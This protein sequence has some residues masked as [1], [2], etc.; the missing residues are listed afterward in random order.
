MNNLISTHPQE[1]IEISDE[2]IDRVLRAVGV[3]QRPARQAP[4]GAALLA[5]ATEVAA[6]R[7]EIATLE[8]RLQTAEAQADHDATTPLFNRRA[9]DRE[10]S[11]TIA[12]VNRHGG[13]LCLLY[14]DL[15]HFKLVNDRFGHLTGDDVLIHVA[16]LLASQTRETDIVARL[17][18]DEFAVALPHAAL[19]DAQKKARSLASAIEKIK[20][21]DPVDPT[22]TPVKV[23]AS[24]GVAEW[25]PGMTSAELI[26]RADEA[27]FVDKGRRK[28]GEAATR[29]P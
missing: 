4:G 10:L 15:D 27:M 19:I 14:I 7:A 2:V 29:H 17:G 11:R 25:R 16:G 20:V 13:Q 24:I 23:G 22:L 12:M 5:L 9:F 28:R 21:V 8:D 3:S 26:R 1:P 6:L 18:G